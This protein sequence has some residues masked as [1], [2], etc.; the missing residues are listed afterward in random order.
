MYSCQ[1]LEAHE[2]MINWQHV[3]F[4]VLLS[5]RKPF[6]QYQILLLVVHCHLLVAAD[7]QCRWHTG[8]RGWRQLAT[9]TQRAGPKSAHGQRR[10]MPR[11]LHLR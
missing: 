10:S 7:L 11:C 4:A 8:Q 1:R 6:L 9:P 5:P 3:P 2:L